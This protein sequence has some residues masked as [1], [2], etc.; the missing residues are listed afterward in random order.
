MKYNIGI[1]LT[2]ETEWTCL[3]DKEFNDQLFEKCALKLVVEKDSIYV[4]Y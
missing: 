1:V 4:T 2:G 3:D